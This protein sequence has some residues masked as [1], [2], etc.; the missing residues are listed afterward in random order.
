MLTFA[1]T[2]K[3]KAMIRYAFTLLCFSS[4]LDE[5]NRI[6][7]RLSF[8]NS[9][10]VRSLDPLVII[11]MNFVE[12]KAFP[13]RATSGN[14]PSC[15]ASRPADDVCGILEIGFGA[16]SQPHLSDLAADCIVFPGRRGVTELPAFPEHFRQSI[17]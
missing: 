14:H 17:K 6:A 16:H 11:M 13:G 10:S 2:A 4:F 5:R 1:Q 7:Q 15:G 12:V 8:N 3:V 9:D